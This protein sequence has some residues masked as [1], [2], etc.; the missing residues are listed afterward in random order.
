MLFDSLDWVLPGLLPGSYRGIMFHVP[1][2][3]TEPGRRVVEYLFPGIDDAAYDDFGQAPNAVSISGMIMGDDYI[4]QAKALEAAFNAAGPA[5]LI[6]PW[7]GPMTVIM[8]QPAQISFSDRELRIVRFSATF[9]RMDSTGSLGVSGLGDLTSAVNTVVIAATT[10]AAVV[11]TVISA[12]RSKAV[13]RSRRITKTVIDNLSAPAGSGRTLPRI[14]AEVAASAPA[15]PVAF[16]SLAQSSAAL[17]NGLTS[18]PAVAPAAEAP[19][20]QQ[21]TAI[22]LMNLGITI[23][24]ALTDASNDAPSDADRALLASAASHFLAQSAAQSVYADYGSSKEALAFRSRAT[25]AA[26]TL[27]DSLESFSA[28]AFLASASVLRRAARDLQAAIIADINETI[29]RLPSVLSFQSDRPLDAWLLAQHVYGDTP[30][31]IED[32]YLDI[33]ARNDP[34]HPAALPA[35]TIEVIG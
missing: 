35:G 24:A 18:E 1:D 15:D 6:H 4:V 17:I 13:S 32:A 21:P 10:L 25:K 22:S 31:R 8:E 23:S 20:E 19:K 14:K 34:R 5:T 7:L 12:T 26:D 29:G 33:V 30:S 27:I 2:T 28:D 16:D 3:T 9:K 11:S